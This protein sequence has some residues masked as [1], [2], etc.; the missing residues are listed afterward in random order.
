MVYGT[1]P[2]AGLSGPVLGEAPAIHVFDLKER[3]DHVLLE[4]TEWFMLS[5]DGSE[6]LYSAPAASA[7]GS[8]EGDAQ[9]PRV[10]GIGD[11]V[12][13][14]ASA[15]P[16]KGGDGALDLAELQTEFD[17]RAEW[18]EMFNDV[19]RQEPAYFFEPAMNGVDWAAQRRKYAQLAPYVAD[20]YDL[21]YVL[22][23]MIGELSNSHTYVGGDYRDLH[24]V[25]VGLLGADFEADLHSLPVW[26]AGTTSD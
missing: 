10:Y 9:P 17:P 8:A 7:C 21:I 15:P 11:A 1:T 13:P 4:G 19:W 14:G 18:M 5:F 22:G 16:H 3:K 12:V 2:V 24:R 23:G 26:A 6:L 25:N 20:R